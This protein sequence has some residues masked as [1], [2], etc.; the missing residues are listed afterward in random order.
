[1]LLLLG[2]CAPPTTLDPWS[3]TVLACTPGD[4]AAVDDV[5]D[6]VCTDAVLADVHTADDGSAE[7]TALA[8][9]LRWLATTDYGDTVP[10]ADP[11]VSVPFVDTLAATRDELGLPGAPG[12]QL[13]YDLVVGRVA[14]VEVDPDGYVA[15]GFDGTLHVA[16]YLGRAGAA[17]AAATLVHEARHRDG[18]WEDHVPCLRRPDGEPPGCDLDGTGAVGFGLSALTLNLRAMPVWQSA[19]DDGSVEVLE[20]NRELR[21]RSDTWDGLVYADRPPGDLP[22]CGET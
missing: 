22:M 7:L 5:P 16:A 10:F 17:Y 15:M 6:A 4:W 8:T 14:A 11:W 9:A 18:P 2:A 1:M 13:L 19:C 21:Y 3:S 20:R 12:A